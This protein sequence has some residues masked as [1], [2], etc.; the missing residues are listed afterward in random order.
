MNQK[1]PVAIAAGA[2]LPS[3]DKLLLA[4]SGILCYNKTNYAENITVSARILRH[5][6]II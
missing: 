2:F 4:V 1:A 5:T 6:M 3:A